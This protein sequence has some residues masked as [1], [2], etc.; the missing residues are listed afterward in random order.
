MIDSAKLKTVLL[1]GFLVLIAGSQLALSCGLRNDNAATSGNYI[2]ALQL[3]AA[4]DPDNP[5]AIAT[6]K[7]T[8]IGEQEASMSIGE[9]NKQ[10]I[11]TEG[12]VNEGELTIGTTES[13]IIKSD[14]HALE[15]TMLLVGHDTE[16]QTDGFRIKV[17]IE[18]QSSNRE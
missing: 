6:P 1:T 9:P 10:F 7:I 8:V 4:S 17:P 5:V 11:E 18:Q 2:A 12:V 3:T 13:S 14:H 15:K 16:F